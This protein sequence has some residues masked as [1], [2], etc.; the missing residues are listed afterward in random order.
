M[1]FDNQSKFEIENFRIN[2][3]LLSPTQR[4]NLIQFNNLLI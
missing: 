3:D 2:D 1:Y 4:E